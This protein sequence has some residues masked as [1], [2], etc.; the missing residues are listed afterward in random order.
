MKHRI[1]LLLILAIQIFS[2]RLTSGQHNQISLELGYG[3]TRDFGDEIPHWMHNYKNF[4]NY[5]RIGVFYCT[6]LNGSNLNLNA[7]INLDSNIERKIETP[8]NRHDITN[9][10]Y[11]RVPL[12]IELHSGKKIQ[13]ITGLGLFMSGLAFYSGVYQYSDFEETLKRIQFGGY[14]N[15]GFEYQ[16]HEKYCLG[17]GL[18]GNIDFTKL[19]EEWRISPGGSDYTIGKGKG[20]D[21]FI[22]INLKYK[23]IS[24][25]NYNCQH[26]III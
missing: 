14:S 22:K 16:I 23:L 21:I 1:T 13:I 19:Y 18:Q 17:I 20:Y 4:Q 8:D 3:R 9:L 25:K 11:I 12:G 24:K 7:G 5:I 2:L 15:F 26:A 6:P 10:S